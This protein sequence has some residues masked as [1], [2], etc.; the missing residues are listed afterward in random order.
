MLLVMS[1]LMKYSITGECLKDL[2]NL[3]S[4]HCPPDN[5]LP[6]SISSFKKWFEDIK[7]PLKVHKYCAFCHMLLGEEDFVSGLCPNEVCNKFVSHESGIS[8]F[9]E[10]PIADQ[11]VSFFQKPGF[12]KDIQNRFVRCKESES[13]IE[14]IYDGEVYRRLSG[15]GQ[16]LSSPHNLSLMWN[17]DGVQC[18]RSSNMTLWPLFFQ[19]NELP[20]AQRISPENMVLG[21]LWFGK[22]KP[23]IMSFTEPFVGSLQ[24]L[25]KDGV[26]V[27]HPD[28]DFVSKV[29]VIGGSADLP[30]RSL[31]L[32]TTQYNGKHGCCKCLQPGETCKVSANGH[33]HVFPFDGTDP[34][35]P[36]RTHDGHVEDAGMAA[37][38]NK[39]CRGVKG[40]C[41][42]MCL[43]YYNL[44][45]GTCI[46]YMHG[47]LLG[48]TKL[49]LSL[50]FMPEHSKKPFSLSSKLSTMDARM[51]ALRPPNVI[52]RLP[53]SIQEHLKHFKASELRSWLLYYSLPLLRDLQGEEYFQHY[54]LL[55]NAVFLLLQESV[56]EDD[57]GKAD[58]LLQH[59][60]CTFAALYGDRY[61]TCNVHQLLH[62]PDM[63][64]DMGPLWV[65]SCFSFE[66]ANGR[67]LK[68][69]NG[70]Q[71]VDW[72]IID[73][74][75]LL[76]NLPRF[77]DRFFRQDS[78]A[79]DCL[80]IMEGH[81]IMKDRRLED[82]VFLVGGFQK[83]NLSVDESLAVSE[84]MGHVTYS[85]FMLQQSKNWQVHLFFKKVLS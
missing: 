43:M 18:F 5:L 3:I 32:N 23:S 54:L 37:E 61:M 24:N 50:W 9:I 12:L 6:R 81:N 22:S 75:N 83:R 52:K 7:N 70:T 45:S 42:L 82:G 34:D 71:K 68:M 64:K 26:F 49:L 63:V 78:E 79:A 65:Y 40:P 77:H 44:V 67:L 30:A 48:V 58:R 25:E 59:F 13:A 11:I 55:V 84:Y 56:S 62:L 20:Y 2:L 80:R 35:G 29:C 47:V 69:F 36:K 17:T 46:D 85:V 51:K 31:V 53:R 76:Q 14:D 15:E 16:I 33:V 4:L 66:N 21:G 57:V 8:H 27:T 19:I 73:G 74:V 72:Q 38:I 41:F 39:T 28:G 10:L 60:C 1:F